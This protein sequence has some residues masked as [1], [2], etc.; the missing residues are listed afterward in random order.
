MVPVCNQETGYP[1]ERGLARIKRAVD[2]CD[3]AIGT[4]RIVCLGGN[5]ADDRGSVAQLYADYIIRRDLKLAQ[6]VEAV[7]GGFVTADD[8]QQLVKGKVVQDR[9]DIVVVTDVQHYL[10]I[11]WIMRHL[12]VPADNIHH[13]P[14]G[15]EVLLKDR[16]LEV[17]VLLLTL[18]DPLWKG[19]LGR[20]LRGHLERGRK[21]S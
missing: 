2:E 8:F 13:A 9:H 17:G 7:P 21:G 5:Y 6:F 15:E 1:D 11:W 20:W 3:T 19:S 18:V 4:R 16:L 12:G 14:S 10:R